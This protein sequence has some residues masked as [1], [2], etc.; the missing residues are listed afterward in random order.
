MREFLRMMGLSPEQIEQALAEL[1][2][3]G[4]MAVTLTKDGPVVEAINLPQSSGK[5]DNKDESDKIVE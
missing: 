3:S 4:F 2:S 5:V 1:E